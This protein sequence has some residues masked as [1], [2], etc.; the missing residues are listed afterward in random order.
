MRLTDPSESLL[1]MET[2]PATAIPQAE[3]SQPMRPTLVKTLKQ[4]PVVQIDPNVAPTGMVPAPLRELDEALQALT[5]ESIR[6]NV[7]V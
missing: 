1:P 5:K 6:F 3:F 7:G 2:V 4:I